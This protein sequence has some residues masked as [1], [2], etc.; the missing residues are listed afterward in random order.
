MNSF[1]YMA[2]LG[3]AVWF[4]GT[5]TSPAPESIERNPV[6]RS[7]SSNYCD[8]GSSAY[9]FATNFETH[10]ILNGLDVG[11]E[12]YLVTN[13]LGVFLATSAM[14][15]DGGLITSDGSGNGSLKGV[16]TANLLTA[17]LASD[18]S[19]PPSSY[20]FQWLSS[21][22]GHPLMRAHNYSSGYELP[23]MDYYTWGGTF[24]SWSYIDGPTAT[25]WGYFNV[26]ESLGDFYLDFEPD[27]GKTLY[28]NFNGTVAANQVGVNNGSPA[29][30]LDVGG[31][32][33]FSGNLWFAGSAIFQPD[34]LGNGGTTLML[35]AS[36]T[37][38]PMYLH[39][40]SLGNITATS[41]P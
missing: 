19:D 15:F 36:D 13:A 8:L 10:L 23:M 27:N 12:L 25:R 6:Y 11:S 29:Y 40:D 28:A 9:P 22:T 41:T 30:T 21:S 3:L 34:S 1:R 35:N 7:V 24:I 2:V 32:I 37:G 38:T 14:H 33:N 5:S 18:T 26:N 39:V 31:D 16:A 4:M 17:N 20:G